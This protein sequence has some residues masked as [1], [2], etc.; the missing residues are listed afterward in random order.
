[1]T[2]G[3]QSYL[4][5]STGGDTWL[6]PTP[7]VSGEVPR[8]A[9]SVVPGGRT[10]RR[11]FRPA[12][13]PVLKSFRSV[14]VRRASLGRMGN[15]RAPWQ[16]LGGQGSRRNRRSRGRRRR[17]ALHRVGRS[18]G[19]FFKSGCPLFSLSLQKMERLGF[20]PRRPALAQARIASRVIEI[21]FPQAA[22]RPF[23][24]NSFFLQE[25]L[26]PKTPHVSGAL[27]FENAFISPY[28]LQDKV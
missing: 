28:Y 21:V 10:G 3:V 12:S 13:P 14:Q 20:R 4:R 25:G 16:L 23:C 5:S 15:K 17:G 8:L 26:F 11:P 24:P 22:L 1:M 18:P 7:P 9:L 19:L 27:P 6:P 2:C